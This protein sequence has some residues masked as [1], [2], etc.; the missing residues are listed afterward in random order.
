MASRVTCVSVTHSSALPPA[1]LSRAVTPLTLSVIHGQG[2]AEEEVDVKGVDSS[3]KSTSVPP[4]AK[5]IGRAIQ[6]VAPLRDSSYMR[7]L[8][9]GKEEKACQLKEEETEGERKALHDGSKR[10]RARKRLN[11]SPY[12]SIVILSCAVSRGMRNLERIK[13]LIRL[14]DPYGDSSALSSWG[15][16]RRSTAW[17][18]RCSDGGVHECL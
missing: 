14:A 5:D 10:R 7:V 16:S 4:R 12:T 8:L 18:D 9:R 3:S 11:S 15:I 6:A 13:H 1:L 17:L 2:A